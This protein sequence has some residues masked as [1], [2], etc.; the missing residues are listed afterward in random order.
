MTVTDESTVE[1]FLVPA[2][3][4]LPSNRAYLAHLAASAGNPD[5]IRLASN[6]NTEP[7][8]PRVREALERAFSDAN[9]SPP[10]TPPLQVALAERYA[11]EAAQVIV[12]AGSTEVIDAAFRTFLRAGDQV[13]LPDP[14]WPV[15][16]RR[17]E[18]L[19]ACVVDVPLTVDEHGFHYD[20]T[21]VLEA[22]GSATRLVVI[23]TPNNPTG[24]AMELDDIKRIADTGVPLLLD[25]AYADFDP[26]RDPMH[27][28]HEYENVIITRT[29]SKA[30][31]LAG[32]RVGYAVGDARV[33]DF[34][35][36][37]LG[38]GSAV[39]SPALHAGLAA[40]EDEAYH[41]H[42]IARITSERER[43]V[44]L[45]RNLGLRAYS[46]G[47]NFVAVDCSEPPIAA[48]FAASV[49]TQG[50]VIRPLGSLVRI[51]IGRRAENDAL[52][53]AV[54]HVIET[55]GAP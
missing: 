30:Y 22:I 32:V 44:P 1:P 25:A 2:A 39:S 46:S 41:Q 51:S 14:S 27:L 43:L 26:A 18:A 55:E 48:S 15:F 10:P 8:S 3:L 31:C 29:F 17:L 53:A 36:R 35:D 9:L 12:T 33:L 20:A 6:E 49:L 54:T 42:Q 50:V 7:P 34:V 11:V 21:C 24:N 28:V 52:V 47:G 23:C 5:L 40:F 13:V 4:A 37:F 38:P 19:E 45:L 16:R